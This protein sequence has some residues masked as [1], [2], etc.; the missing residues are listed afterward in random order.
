[1]KT[2]ASLAL[3]FLLAL[4]AVPV[5]AGADGQTNAP[6]AYNTATETNIDVTVA[7]VREVAKSEPLPGVHL[8]VKFK[9]DTI[10]VYLAPV[11]FVKIFGV[12][13]HNGDE[14]E[15]TGSKVKSSGQ[16]VILAREVQVGR[17]TLEL[18]DKDGTPFW[19]GWS[20]KDFPT[21]D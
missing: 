8:S 18:R 3:A 10:D 5:V 12:T 9:S 11:E 1:M 6:P 16:E 13:F 19:Q 14:I 2:M 20:T 21:G 15:I 4:A 7:D 17:T